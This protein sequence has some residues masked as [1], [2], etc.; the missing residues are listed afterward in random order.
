M[1]LIVRIPEPCHEDWNKM[2]PDE[3]GRFCNVC[4]KSVYDF[5][6]KTDSEIISIIKE[7]SGQQLCGHFKKSQ[8][9]RPLQYNIPFTSIPINMPLINR[10]AAALVFVF[11][12]FLFSCTNNDGKEIKLSGQIPPTTSQEVPITGAPIETYVSPSIEETTEIIQPQTMVE[13]GMAYE[14]TETIEAFPELIQEPTIE[15]YRTL[16]GAIAY[17][18]YPEKSPI[19]VP[20]EVNEDSTQEKNTALNL[21]IDETK[22][23]PNPSNGEF[24]I[25]YEIKQASL[26]QIDIYDLQGKLI[27]NI[28]SSQRQNT[29]KYVLPTNLSELPNGIYICKIT[30]DGKVQSK[31]IV[32]E[33]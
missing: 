26:V 7:N 14:V 3:K 1:Q 27:K 31:K 16:G 28:V 15:N 20:T 21:N 17:E 2:Q 12:S 33:K 11:G 29:G 9:D 6:N 4:T 32:I 8:L 22:I 23:F 30:I 24:N 25:N 10:F 5:S 13:G 19:S 18:I